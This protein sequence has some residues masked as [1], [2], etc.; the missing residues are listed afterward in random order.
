MQQVDRLHDNAASSPEQLKTVAD[1]KRIV[2][3]VTHQ[4]NVEDLTHAFNQPQCPNYAGTYAFEQA[5][6]NW[7]G[8]TAPKLLKAWRPA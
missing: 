3:L 8:F 7:N 1:D 5:A 2:L 4:P 6:A